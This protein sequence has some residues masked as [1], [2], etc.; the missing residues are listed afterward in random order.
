M[1]C[2]DT[3]VLVD[4][5]GRSG[6]ARA[7]T[8]ADFVADVAREDGS[9]VTT[10]LCLAELYVGIERGHDPEAALAAMSAVI[11]EIEV[12]EFDDGAAR[13]FGSIKAEL[14]DRGEPVGDVDLLIAAIAVRHDHALITSNVRDFA[15][16]PGLRVK[17]C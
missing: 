15:R 7:A 3:S 4:L 12:L 1:A 16:V 6:R 17:A 10:R 11:T 14:L 9:L 2:L 8:L 5:L 13:T